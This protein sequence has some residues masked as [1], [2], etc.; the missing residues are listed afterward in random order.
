M[1]WRLYSWITD[2]AL[3]GDL[4]TAVGGRVGTKARAAVQM[5][6]DQRMDVSTHGAQ[7]ITAGPG[8]LI[9]AMVGRLYCEF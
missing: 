8:R 5:Y 6:A 2:V 1:A 3:H 9:T 7:A 4:T